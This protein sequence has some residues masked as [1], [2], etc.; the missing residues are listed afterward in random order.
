MPPLPVFQTN[1][2]P[3]VTV[4]QGGGSSPNSP[5]GA[6][7]H[8]DSTK[9][10]KLTPLVAGVTPEFDKEGVNSDYRPIDAAIKIKIT[11]TA[12]IGPGVA[13]LRVDF[14]SE[15][16]DKFG[17]PLPPIVLIVEEQSGS[18]PVWRT[19]ALSSTGF[20]LLSENALTA[21]LT[22]KIRVLVHSAAAN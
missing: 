19:S 6:D 5:S 21:P 16:V 11:L 3:E 22:L 12:N 1:L 20:G 10:P 2:G 9:A 17:K 18:S 4:D 7:I 15:Y 13:F 8:R 14:G